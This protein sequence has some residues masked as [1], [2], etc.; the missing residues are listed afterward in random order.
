MAVAPEIECP[1]DDVALSIECGAR[2]DHHRGAKRL[3][4]EF[5][6]THPLH[7]HR[8]ACDRARQQ[9]RIERDIVCAVVAVAAGAFGVVDEDILGR[10][11]EHGREIVP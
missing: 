11:V 2:L 10:Q 3:P 4:R 9:Y 8:A 7:L 6:F 5:V 1:V